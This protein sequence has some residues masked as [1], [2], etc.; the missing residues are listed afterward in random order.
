MEYFENSIPKPRNPQIKLGG[1][2]VM[3]ALVIEQKDSCPSGAYTDGK[4][5]CPSEY[6]PKSLDVTRS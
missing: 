5:H 6:W 2:Y 3:L 4:V 1:S